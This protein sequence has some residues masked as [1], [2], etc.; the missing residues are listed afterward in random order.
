MKGTIVKTVTGKGRSRNDVIGG[1]GEAKEMRVE[2]EFIV[3]R[4]R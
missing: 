3:G 1:S 2:E 4:E